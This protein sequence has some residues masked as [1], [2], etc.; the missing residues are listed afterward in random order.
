[1]YQCQSK[2][3]PDYAYALSA[4]TI[5]EWMQ[6]AEDLKGAESADRNV[7]L[8]IHATSQRESLDPEGAEGV[9]FQ[10]F[11]VSRLYV[12]HLLILRLLLNHVNLGGR[13]LNLSRKRRSAS[14]PKD[15]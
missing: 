4:G 7:K 6:K 2:L 12:M 9:I 11:P 15:P 3:I 1:M 10:Q 13:A 5:I 14:Y 8:N